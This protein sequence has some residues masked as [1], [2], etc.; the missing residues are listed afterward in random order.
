MKNTELIKQ[1]QLTLRYIEAEQF[2]INLPWW[3]N[4]FT[5]GKVTKFL[6][7]RLDKYNF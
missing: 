1:E 6:Q 4:F 7:S 2:I 3:V 5:R